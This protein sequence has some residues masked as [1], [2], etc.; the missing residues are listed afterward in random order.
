MGRDA[1]PVQVH[2]GGCWNAAKRSRGICRD[3][4]L[5]ALADGVRACGMPRRPITVRQS[6]GGRYRPSLPQR[7]PRRLPDDC[8]NEL[9]TALRY[10]RGRALPAADR[11]DL[12]RST[13]PLPMPSGTTFSATS[14]A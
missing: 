7:L 4:A 13:A 6:A 12:P 3:D 10:H 8:L 5:R 2:V 1:L 9:L 14:N 11:C